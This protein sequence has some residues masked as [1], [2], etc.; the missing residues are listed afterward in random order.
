M[1]VTAALLKRKGACPEQY[2]L[3]VKTFG[4]STRVKIT[5]AL[6]VKHASKFD[7]NWAAAHL[8]PPP[9]WAE[10]NKKCAPL[11]GKLAERA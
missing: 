1:I 2:A 11:F 6:C 4:K 7:W 10:Y 9:L 8:L 3:F 5:A